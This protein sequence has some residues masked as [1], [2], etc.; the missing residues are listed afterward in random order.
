MQRREQWSFKSDVV[1]CNVVQC[2]LWCPVCGNA[3]T[4]GEYVQCGAREVAPWVVLVTDGR[5]VSSAYPTTPLPTLETFRHFSIY[6]LCFMLN[7]FLLEV[8]YL[9]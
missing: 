1:L 5:K 3:H 7:N 6:A 9:L 2:T 8:S 4:C